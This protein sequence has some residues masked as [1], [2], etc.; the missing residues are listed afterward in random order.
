MVAPS[1][2]CQRSRRK[3]HDVRADHQVLHDKIR[4]A[5]EARAVRRSCDLDGALPRGSK[6]WTFA[7]LRPRR[8]LRRRLR[9]GRLVHATGFDLRPASGLLEP[10]N[11]SSRCAATVR[12][13][14]ATSSNSFTTKLFRSVGERRS[15]SAGSDIPRMNLTRAVL[16]IVY[17]CLPPLVLPLLPNLVLSHWFDLVV[18]AGGIDRLRSMRA[19]WTCCSSWPTPNSL[20]KNTTFAGEAREQRRLEPLD[21]VALPGNS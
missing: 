14:S 6:A 18:V 21:K 19:S 12:R 5:F 16:E 20:S 1:G 2:F 9:I 7:S 15:R 8:A 13:R 10:R 17:S 4:V 3:F 11:S